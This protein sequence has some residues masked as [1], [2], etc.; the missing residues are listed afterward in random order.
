MNIHEPSSAAP[1]M[2]EH[3]IEQEILTIDTNV[4]GS[5]FTVGRF[6]VTRIEQCTK[7]GMHADIAYIRVWA[8]D[9]CLGEFCQHNLAGVYFKRICP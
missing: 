3:P 9:Q 8:G 5:G 2:I 6:G 1:K 4:D 7:S